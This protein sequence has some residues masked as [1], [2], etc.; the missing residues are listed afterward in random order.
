[1]IWDD[2]FEEMLKGIAVELKLGYSKS[3]YKSRGGY[4]LGND[5]QLIG[6]SNFVGRDGKLKILISP[7]LSGRP[8]DL[9]DY[10]QDELKGKNSK[11]RKVIIVKITEELSKK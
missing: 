11:A 9:G 6:F 2:L 3:G 10:T 8:I 1:M 7:T 5:K 4:I